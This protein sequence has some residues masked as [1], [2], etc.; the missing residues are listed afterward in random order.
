MRNLSLD[1]GSK[2]AFGAYTDWQC[3]IDDIRE[4][5][6]RHSAEIDELGFVKNLVA[7]IRNNIT[8]FKGTNYLYGK[9]K[10]RTKTGKL[11]FHR[12]NAKGLVMN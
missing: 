11:N 1:I 10:N 8:K 12:T 6:I 3:K 7:G 5:S 9:W 2:A 4:R